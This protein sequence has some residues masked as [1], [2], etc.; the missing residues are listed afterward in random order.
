MRFNSLL[1]S[2]KSSVLLLPSLMLNFDCLIFIIT[3]RKIKQYMKKVSITIH[4]L[5]LLR[6]ISKIMLRKVISG[7]ST[8]LV[9]TQITIH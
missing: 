8:F 2:R 7:Y 4:K 5:S 1:F 9:I 3:Q 6:E